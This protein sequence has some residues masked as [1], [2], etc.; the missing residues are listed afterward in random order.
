MNKEYCRG[1]MDEAN[2]VIE[3]LEYVRETGELQ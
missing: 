3:Y 2:G 1:M